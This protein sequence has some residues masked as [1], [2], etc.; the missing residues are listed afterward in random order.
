M[1]YYVPYHRALYNFLCQQP[2]KYFIYLCFRPFKLISSD[3]TIN[4]FNGKDRIPIEE[5]LAMYKDLELSKL[6]FLHSLESLPHDCMIKWSPR[7]SFWPLSIGRPLQMIIVT[8]GNGC[9]NCLFK[10][11][12]FLFSTY[13]NIVVFHFF[14]HPLYC[15]SYQSQK[16]SL[17]LYCCRLLRK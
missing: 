8:H 9:K 4:H 13:V 5:C 12:L 10:P 17:K 2:Q 7:T 11:I 6:T 1:S 3:P 15:F 14:M 16:N